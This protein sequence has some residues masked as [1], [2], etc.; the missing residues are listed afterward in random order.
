MNPG[1]AL[2]CAAWRLGTFH[3]PD[4]EQSASLPEV[5]A[6]LLRPMVGDQHGGQGNSA[7]GQASAN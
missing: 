2:T 3:L 5:P 4:A 1:G 7:P 6:D